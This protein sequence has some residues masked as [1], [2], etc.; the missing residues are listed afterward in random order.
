MANRMVKLKKKSKMSHFSALFT[1][2]TIKSF[3]QSLNLNKMW[4]KNHLKM[5]SNKHR[6]KK[7]KLNLRKNKRKKLSQNSQPKTPKKFKF[8]EGKLSRTKRTSNK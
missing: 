5:K 4:S 8:L 6:K 1:S 2:L 7:R 3:Q